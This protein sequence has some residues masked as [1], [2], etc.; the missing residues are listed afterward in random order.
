MF[1]YHEYRRWFS[2]VQPEEKVVTSFP[3]L[4]GWYAA[5]VVPQGPSQLFA[6]IDGKVMPVNLHYTDGSSQRGYV[7]IPGELIAV[8]RMSSPRLGVHLAAGNSLQYE[9]RTMHTSRI[10]SLRDIE[11]GRR[12]TVLS[13]DGMRENGGR[14]ISHIVGAERL[15]FVC[16]PFRSDYHVM[17]ENVKIKREDVA[18]FTPSLVAEFGER[19]KPRYTKADVTACKSYLETLLMRAE[20]N[21]RAALECMTMTPGRS[22]QF[23]STVMSEAISSLSHTIKHG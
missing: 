13:G 11:S 10:I 2:S 14:K 8:F 19:M 4:E 6:G 7:T 18:R 17:P 5:F 16:Q 23:S 21:D 15:H 20:S 1:V 22:V 9:M 3:P 12:G